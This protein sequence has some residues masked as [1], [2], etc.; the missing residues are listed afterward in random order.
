MINYKMLGGVNMKIIKNSFSIIM[1]ILLIVLSNILLSNSAHGMGEY[2]V[3]AWDPPL[4]VRVT[5]ISSFLYFFL[6]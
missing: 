5:G 2:K 3:A 1:W 4:N 6:I